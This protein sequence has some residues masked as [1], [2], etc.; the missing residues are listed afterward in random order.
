M[1]ARIEQLIWG[2][3]P[4]DL[5]DSQSAKTALK[6][7]GAATMRARRSKGAKR[8]IAVD[9]QG[10]LLTAVAHSAGIQDRIGAR[11]VL[12]RLFYRFDTIAKVFVDGGYTGTLMKL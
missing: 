5:T 2:H 8:H 10:S 4:H 9:T 12:T 11:A 7:G 6:G 3:V 1:R